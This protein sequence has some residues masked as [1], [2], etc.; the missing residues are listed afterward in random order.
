M[1]GKRLFSS[2]LALASALLCTALVAV[3]SPLH[4]AFANVGSCPMFPAN[5]IWNIR[6]DTLPVHPRSDAYINAIGAGVTVHPDF[7]SAL[8]EGGPIGIPYMTVPGT[9]P[10]VTVTFDY[11]GESDPGPY[12]ISTGTPIEWGSDHHALVVDSDSCVLYELY[13]VSQVGSTWHAGSGAIWNLNSNALRP[14]GW[15]SA[16]AAGL[17]ILPGLARYDE[18]ASGA[19]NHALRFTA[20]NLQETHIWPARHMDPADPN[21]DLPPY[22]QR[23]RLK[24]SFDIGPYSPQTRVILTAL[25]QYGMFLADMG[26]P[27]YI[28]GAPDL[29]WDDSALVQDLRNVH[30]SDFEAVDESSVMQDPNSGLAHPWVPT[31]WVDLPFLR[32]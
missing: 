7:G 31:N 18:V 23:F 28:S 30:G 10:K 3:F 32:K 1:T 5:N 24:A 13:A 14:E 19:I 22:G 25:K 4:S 6:I 17:P 15:T 11:A 29:G 26:A 21:L 2:R 27:W 8:W 12:P 9:E 16:D 20:E